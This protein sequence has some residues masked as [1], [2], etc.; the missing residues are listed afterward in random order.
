MHRLQKI[1]VHIH[2]DELDEKN[3]SVND[4][5]N[6]CDSSKNITKNNSKFLGNGHGFG[7]KKWWYDNRLAILFYIFQSV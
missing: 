1:H 3:R 2:N 7:N 6:N 5:I 4:N